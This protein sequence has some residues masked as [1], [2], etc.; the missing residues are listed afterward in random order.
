MSLCQHLR[1]TRC[2]R[3]TKNGISAWPTEWT[4]ERL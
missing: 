1:A 3:N 4:K 2:C